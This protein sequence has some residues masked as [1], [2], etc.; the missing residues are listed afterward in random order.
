M[1]GEDSGRKCRPQLGLGEARVNEAGEVVLWNYES[2][3]KIR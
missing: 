3:F 2:D 1:E